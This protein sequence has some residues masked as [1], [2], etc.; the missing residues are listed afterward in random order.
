MWDLFD[1]DREMDMDVCLV[2][3]DL[4]DFSQDDDDCE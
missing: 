3:F 1:D 2:D 4:F